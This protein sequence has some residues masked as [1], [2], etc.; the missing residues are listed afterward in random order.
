MAG[1]VDASAEALAAAG[2]SISRPRLGAVLAELTGLHVQV[3]AYDVARTLVWE[4]ARRE[5]LSPQLVA[6]IDQG[7]AISVDELHAARARVEELRAVVLAAIDGCDAVLAAG[8][9][10]PAPEGLGSTGSPDESR[11]WHVLGLPAVALPAG[12]TTDGLPLGVQLVGR[13]F[14]DDALLAL[15]GWAALVLGPA[16]VPSLVAG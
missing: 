5:L 7:L 16:P 4:D 10:G 14:G 6:Q 15:A 1:A 8:A 9:P 13:R 2:A 12:V 11:P 3:M